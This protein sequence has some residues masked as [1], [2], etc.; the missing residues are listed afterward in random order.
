M[1][2][3]ERNLRARM[4]NS[5]FE[6][7]YRAAFGRLRADRFGDYPLHSVVLRMVQD[8]AHMQ[9]GGS[10]TFMPFGAPGVA[11]PEPDSIRI[12]QGSR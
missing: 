10:P 9:N 11:T 6:A 5:N 4:G 1:N 8:L 7:A 12:L 2:E 3:L